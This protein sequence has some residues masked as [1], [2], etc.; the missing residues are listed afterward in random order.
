LRYRY[1][2]FNLSGKNFSPW[3]EEYVSVWLI[4]PSVQRFP[5]T[6][7]SKFRYSGR[8]EYQ[9]V[10]ESSSSTTKTGS[11]FLSSRRV[12]RQTLPVSLERKQMSRAA[13]TSRLLASPEHSSIGKRKYNDDIWERLYSPPAGSPLCQTLPVNLSRS[14]ATN[15]LLTSPEH[16]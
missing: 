2:V 13:T 8:T 16:S 3:I 4:S 6:L 1:T 14:A 12:L 15:R 7:S 5:F 9:T 11:G 10:Q